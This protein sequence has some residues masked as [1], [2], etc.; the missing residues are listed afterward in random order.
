MEYK[1]FPFTDLNMSITSILFRRLTVLV[2][3]SSVCVGGFAFLSMCVWKSMLLRLSYGQLRWHMYFY[4]EQRYRSK[5]KELQKEHR[6]EH[7]L[8]F[9]VRSYHFINDH[10]WAFIIFVSATYALIVFLQDLAVFLS[11]APFISQ[12]IF[13][14]K[15]GSKHYA[16]LSLSKGAGDIYGTFPICRFWQACSTWQIGQI[17]RIASLAKKTKDKWLKDSKT[18]LKNMTLTAES[19]EH[20]LWRENVELCLSLPPLSA[21]GCRH[22]FEYCLP[23]HHLIQG[24]VGLLC[25]WK[26]LLTPWLN[27]QFWTVLTSQGSPVDFIR[28]WFPH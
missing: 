14:A 4:Y 19:Q 8:D 21:I 13:I 23:P 10:L 20:S 12:V 9:A 27:I 28:V 2:R 17:G 15:V 18:A 26:H 22:M 16:T 5:E 11:V 25:R 1:Y 3:H 7:C 24:L 6:H